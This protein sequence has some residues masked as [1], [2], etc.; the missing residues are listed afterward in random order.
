MT[1]AISNY[2]GMVLSLRRRM[3]QGLQFGFYYTFSH[4]LDEVSNA[5][6][7]PFDSEY[8]PEHSE[9][10]EPLQHS[11]VQLRQCR[12]R[13]TPL[14][15]GK[16]R[17]GRRVPPYLQKARA[18]TF[19]SPAGRF[20]A[21]C[22]SAPGSRSRWWIARPAALSSVVVSRDRFSRLPYS[23]ATTA[24]ARPRPIRIHLVFPSTSS[25][26][27]PTSPPDSA[28]RPEISTADRDT[29]IRT[30]PSSKNFKIPHWEAAKFGVGFQFFNILN[31]PN[32]DKPV[33]DIAQG[34][35]AF[36][37]ITSLVSSPT[38]IFGGLCRRRRL[39]PHHPAQ[40]AICVLT[41]R[42]IRIFPRRVPRWRIGTVTVA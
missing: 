34:A 39:R 25:R 36:G 20:P 24:A 37:T 32:F 22:S 10:S 4:A 27:A 19:W 1:G 23:R 41:S 3:A 33:N 6:Y 35:G 11:P 42:R 40:S 8:R 18:R 9:P 31:H 12:L 14:H 29:S 16:L 2:R 17:V 7:F 30:C 28:T 15:F 13:R 38:S 26:R 5:G 21:P